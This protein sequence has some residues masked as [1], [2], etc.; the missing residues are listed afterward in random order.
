VPLP[1]GAPEQAIKKA[2]TT[3]EKRLMDPMWVHVV[4]HVNAAKIWAFLQDRADRPR[5]GHG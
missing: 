1:D 3:R 2:A 4:C 5:S